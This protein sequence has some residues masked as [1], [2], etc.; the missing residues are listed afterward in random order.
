MKFIVCGGRDFGDN[1]DRIRFPEEYELKERQ[2]GFIR[3]TLEYIWNVKQ[4]EIEIA[5]G[6]ARGADA[7]T[8]EWCEHNEVPFNVYYANWDKYGKAAGFL[9]N[10]QMYDHFQPDAVLAF[11]GGRGTEMMCKIAKE[12]G[13]QVK[14][15]EFNENSLFTNL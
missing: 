12:G 8:R 5:T 11:P 15:F 6:C 10:S 7:V 14:K 3:F 13:T 1:V 2:K 9:R 4:G